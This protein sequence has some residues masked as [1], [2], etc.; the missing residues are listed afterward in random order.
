MEGKKFD[1]IAYMSFLD[2]ERFQADYERQF[3]LNVIRQFP[4]KTFLD[5]LKVL[6]HQAFVTLTEF[7]E[8]RNN[9]IE[10]G[11]QFT[12]S[13]ENT[14]ES[15]S[16]IT[17]IAMFLEEKIKFENAKKYEQVAFI[18][19]VT[20]IESEDPEP[21]TT[22]QIEKVG[23]FIRSGIVQFLREKNPDIKDSDIS[24]FIRELT[25][26]YLENSESVRP[27]LTTKL[28]SDKH[29]FYAMGRK[30]S[31][32]LILKKYKINPQSDS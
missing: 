21:L 1:D 17:R 14:L 31:L 12:S 28:E 5:Y 6:N 9:L 16:Q 10:S 8:I 26:E 29:P 27:H 24:K 30:D 3:Y 4:N 25:S 11:K 20:K 32:D 15:I 22:K 18:K 13:Y 19:Q 23:L 2:F 7:Y